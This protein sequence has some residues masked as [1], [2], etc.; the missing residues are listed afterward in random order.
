MSTEQFMVPLQALTGLR[1]ECRDRAKIAEQRDLGSVTAWQYVADRLTD[2]ATETRAQGKGHPAYDGPS[3]EDRAAA[4]A[5][6]MLAENHREQAERI[7]ARVADDE[8]NSYTAKAA[9]GHADG[10][11]RVARQIDHALLIVMEHTGLGPE[12]LTLDPPPNPLNLG[13]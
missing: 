6:N 2:I 12:D 10:W 7:R 9:L 1:S 5:L 4:R 8:V 3:I 11:D 13:K